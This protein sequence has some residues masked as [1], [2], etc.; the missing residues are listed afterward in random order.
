MNESDGP[1]QDFGEI[2]ELL[3]LDDEP[4][5]IKISQAITD[6]GKKP[7]TLSDNPLLD[8]ALILRLTYDLAS[9]THPPEQIAVRYGLGDVDGLKDYLRAHPSIVSEAAQLR[10]ENELQGGE[11]Q[12]ETRVRKKFLH[13]TEELIM[14]V[15]GIVADPRTPI[16]ARIDG[17]KQLQRGA[18]LD[19]LPPQARQ[20]AR[21]MG[22]PFNLTINF[23]A[24][25]RDAVN[26]VAEVLDNS[27]IPALSSHPPLPVVDSNDEDESFEDM[28]DEV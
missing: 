7:K 10:K 22:Q 19:G 17:F 26:I 16:S 8:D 9:R 23:G 18:G 5:L 14:P 25:G 11:D 13:A 1:D 20:Q 4:D 15:A 12:D 27:Q 21:E 2:D 28:G 24:G 3:E 6:H